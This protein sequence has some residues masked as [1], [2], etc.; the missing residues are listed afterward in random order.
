MNNYL[1]NQDL[2]SSG[3]YRAKL[4][5]DGAE[6]RIY[7][8]GIS[9]PSKTEDKKCLSIGLFS[10]IKMKETALIGESPC[11][12]VFENGDMKRPIIVGYF[13][14]GIRSIGGSVSNSDTSNDSSNNNSNNNS[15]NA[16][17]INSYIQ[18]VGGTPAKEHGP[19]DGTQCVELCNHYVESVFGHK[20]NGGFGNG[21][22]YYIGISSSYPN[23]FEKIVYSLG[24]TLQP[25]DIISLEGAQKQWGHAAIVKSVSGNDIT[26]LEQWDGSGTVR[27]STFTLTNSGNRRIIG[28][29]RPK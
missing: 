28:I 9:N 25:G 6:A 21:N 1:I 11:W 20:N 10:S 18:T 4:F 2:S 17:S 14:N 15:V 29:A 16:T 12:V 5:W 8:P 7:V 26:I 22:T 27:T 3:I 19:G 13:G 23:T 24:V